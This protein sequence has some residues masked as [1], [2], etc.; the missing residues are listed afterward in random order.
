MIGIFWGHCVMLWLWC[1]G[2]FYWTP[3]SVDSWNTNN[4][5]ITP[6][7]WYADLFITFICFENVCLLGQILGLDAE[8]PSPLG[9]LQWP[10]LWKSSQSL[11]LRQQCFSLPDKHN[12]KVRYQVD[13]VTTFSRS[14][15]Y[16]FSGLSGS[17][18]VHRSCRASSDKVTCC[19]ECTPWGEKR[20]VSRFMLACSILLGSH[21]FHT[22]WFEVVFWAEGVTKANMRNMNRLHCP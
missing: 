19:S 14:N 17:T 6:D 13:P 11:V 16:S 15:S 10:E 20:Q 7:I 1:E 22:C 5:C 18:V 8:L 3:T 9:N 21:H 4:T 2:C 12:I